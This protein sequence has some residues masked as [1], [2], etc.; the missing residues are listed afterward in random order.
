MNPTLAYPYASFSRRLAAVLLDVLILIL[1]GAL[2][3]SLIPVAGGLAV[4]FLYTPFLEASVMRATIGKKL[5]GI[6]VGSLTNER[7]TFRAAMIR[8]IMKVVS[9]IFLCLPHLLA[10]FTERRQA[11][12]DLVADTTVTNGRVEVPAADAWI[13][14]IKEVFRGGAANTAMGGAA[15]GATGADRIAELERLQ[16]LHERGALTREEFEREKTRVLGSG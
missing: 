7:I 13:A 9:G 3:G 15:G 1:P 4:Y 6:Q 14:M 12:H 5:M 10:L 8:A 16:S 11:F 2:L